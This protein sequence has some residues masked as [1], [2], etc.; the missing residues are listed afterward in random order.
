MN[1][2][3]KLWYCLPFVAAFALIVALYWGTFAWWV[4]EW[5]YPGSF[6]AHAMFV[7]FFVAIMVW[8]NRERLTLARWEPA[9]FGLVPIGLAMIILMLGQ[10]LEVTTIQSLS[11]VGR[12]LILLMM[13]CLIS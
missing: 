6:Y 12:F 9:W 5:T 4:H 13:T 3:S 7:P 8:R 2:K 10:R 11:S 1:Q